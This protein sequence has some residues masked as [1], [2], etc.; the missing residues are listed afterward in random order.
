[1]ED[2][3]ERRRKTQKKEEGRLKRKKKEDSRGKR[4]MKLI[5]FCKHSR[6]SQVQQKNKGKK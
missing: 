6:H 5:F 1:V 3:K 4:K 2:S